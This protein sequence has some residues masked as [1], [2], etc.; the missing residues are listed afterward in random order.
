[1]Y[2]FLSADSLFGEANVFPVSARGSRYCDFRGTEISSR[3]E[4]SAGTFLVQN[5][6]LS[7]SEI[8]VQLLNE[9]QSISV[10]FQHTWYGWCT[11]PS[12]WYPSPPKVVQHIF[13]VGLTILEY[14]NSQISFNRHLFKAGTSIAR[15]TVYGPCAPLLSQFTVCI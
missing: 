4:I 6:G 12:K 2:E 10:G 13:Q 5:G 1:M 15:T 9:Y 3:N 8:S 11:N 14:K 7:V